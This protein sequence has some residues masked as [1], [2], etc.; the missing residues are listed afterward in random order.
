M[1]K[2]GVYFIVIALLV[3]Q[4]LFARMLYYKINAILHH[5]EGSSWNKLINKFRIKYTLSRSII[6]VLHHHVTYAAT[7]TTPPCWMACRSNMAREVS[8]RVPSLP[9]YFAGL[10][11]DDK[12]SY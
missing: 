4:L 8:E 7:V 5:F 10:N 2:N 11:L 12:K 6:E 9:G 1:T 3:A